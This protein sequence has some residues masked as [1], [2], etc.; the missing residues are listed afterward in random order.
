[1]HPCNEEDF[2]KFQPVEKR[3]ASVFDSYKKNGGLY[4]IDW[5]S[6]DLD[7]F[8]SGRFDEY[9][10][11]IDILVAPCGMSYTLNDGSLYQKDENECKWDK[12]E[13]VDY[14]GDTFYL[15]YFYNHATF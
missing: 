6:E 9:F 12:D 7:L 10:Q 11:A 13:F 3:S 4:C 8:G 14:L 1:M 5:Q 2:Q 15:T